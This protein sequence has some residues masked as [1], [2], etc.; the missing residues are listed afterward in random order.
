G[1]QVGTLFAYC[2]E[3]GIAQSLKDEVLQHAARGEIDIVTDPRASPTGYPFKVVR[4]KGDHDDGPRRVRKCDLGYLRTA[5]RD[6]NDPGGRIGYRCPAEPV[7]A[8][9]K[10]G[11]S[12]EETEGREC[13]CNGLTS[14]IGQAQLRDGGLAEPPLLTSGDDLRSIHTFVGSRTHYSA[15]DVVDYLLGV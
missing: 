9:V 4:W 6:P 7:D 1:I 3:S 8:Y 13:L 5:Y 12:V 11:G 15:A 14:N 2:E 10:K